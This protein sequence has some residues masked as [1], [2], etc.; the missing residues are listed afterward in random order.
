MIL[1]FLVKTFLFKFILRMTKMFAKCLMS[2]GTVFLLEVNRSPDNIKPQGTAL[3][4]SSATRRSLQPFP[5]PKCP[6]L[7]SQSH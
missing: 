6:D 2:R 7:R 4:E 5:C 3:S 1:P